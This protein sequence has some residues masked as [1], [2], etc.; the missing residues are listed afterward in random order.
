MQWIERER[1]RAAFRGSSLRAGPGATGLQ[2]PNGKRIDL[3]YDEN[4]MKNVLLSRYTSFVALY[5]PVLT[6]PADKMLF[7]VRS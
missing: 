6:S 5:R 4:G 3:P 1:E 7:D 2:E